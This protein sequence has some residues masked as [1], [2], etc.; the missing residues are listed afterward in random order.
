MNFFS[1]LILNL[2][3]RPGITLSL[4]FAVAI[5]IG[6][7]LLYLPQAVISERLN[8]IN[9]LFTAVSATTVTGLIVK[10]TATHF[11]RFG[12][13]VI[14]GLIQIG[15]LGIMTGAVVFLLLIKRKINIVYRATLRRILDQDFILETLYFI[16]FIIIVTFTIE[17]IGAFLLFFYWELPYLEISD[18]I[19]YSVFHSVSAF[20]NAGFSLFTDSLAG[21]KG[22]LFFN[23][24]IMILIVVGGLGF[25]VL[26]DMKDYFILRKNGS[27]GK[28]FRMHIHTKITLIVTLILIIVGSLALLIFEKE[29]PDFAS[30]PILTSYF[31]SITT[32]TAGFSTVDI[33]N[34]SGPTYLLFIL[35]MF[36]GG[37]VGSTAGGIK[38]TTAAILFL[39]F[40]SFI[41][42][43]REVSVFGRTLPINNIKRAVVVFTFSSAIIILF[44]VLLLYTEKGE[45]HNI[46]F[47]AFSAFGTVGLSV[48]ITPY[49]TF[50]GKIFIIILMFIGRIGPLTIALITA[51]EAEEEIIKYPH[52]RILVG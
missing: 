12:Q 4:G 19:F 15:A 9:A 14:L 40:L 23:I 48:G 29:N 25:M 50:V 37:G 41:R 16:K 34:L 26:S 38:V 8:F 18:K 47:E 45:F 35:F 31:Q 27:K 49:L 39:L 20:A 5:F 46:V 42:N 13:M 3:H 2:I 51:R 22:E 6:A 44:S 43:R 17:F 36:I 24:I 33:G 52:E 30:H 7:V 1:K 11:S 21:F 32:R 28:L 10:D